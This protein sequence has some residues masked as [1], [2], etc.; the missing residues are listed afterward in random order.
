[1]RLTVFLILFGLL[2]LDATTYAQNMKVN[3]ECK[4]VLLSE[5]MEI[6]KEQTKLDFFYSNKELDVNKKVSISAKEEMLESVL[7]KILGDGYRFRVEDNI[8]IIR[9]VKDDEKKASQETVTTY[10]EE[11]SSP[12]T[13]N[14]LVS[15]SPALTPFKNTVYFPWG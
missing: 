1:M 3:L 5:V 4:D 6:L 12:N 11:G 10:S 13:E 2:R 9:P 14:T 7:R 15:A 8:V